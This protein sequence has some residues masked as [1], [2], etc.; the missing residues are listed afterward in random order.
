MPGSSAS[1]RCSGAG[2]G[3]ERERPG[4]GL[5]KKIALQPSAVAEERRFRTLSSVEPMLQR[6]GHHRVLEQVAAKR[7]GGKLSGMFDADQIGSQPMS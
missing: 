4:T 2:L 1:I 7:T 6:F 3:F 5:A